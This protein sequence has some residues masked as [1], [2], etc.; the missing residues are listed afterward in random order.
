M[1]RSGIKRRL[2]RHARVVCRWAFWLALT[3]LGITGILAITARIWLPWAGEWLSLQPRRA[4]VDV[5][6]VLG[7]G[8]PQRILHAIDLYKRG[9]ARELWH[10][11]DVPQ[12]PESNARLAKQLAIEAGVPASA[13]HVLESTSTWED[14]Q[15]IAMRARSQ[16]IDNLL[17]VTDWYHSRRALAVIDRH[18]GGSDVEVYYDPPQGENER[19]EWWRDADLRIEVIR[20]LIKIGF[21]WLRYGVAFQGGVHER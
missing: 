15:V 3:G 17:V 10:T 21:Y 13:V 2:D 8:H 12:A 1:R 19:S 9:F 5:I 7:G 6:V 4:S 11:G 16:N 14:G 20:E 18:L